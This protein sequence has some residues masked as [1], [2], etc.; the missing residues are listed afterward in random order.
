MTVLRQLT[1]DFRAWV[2]TPCGLFFCLSLVLC[3]DQL[4]GPYALLRYHDWF[5]VIVFSERNFA[6]EMLRHGLVSWTPSMGGMP[7]FVA[8]K[9]PYDIVN[10]LM[11]VVPPWLAKSLIIFLESWA[12]GAG[13]ERLLRTYFGLHRRTAMFGGILFVVSCIGVTNQLF[14]HYFPLFFLCVLDL[15][16]DL[17]FRLRLRAFLLV[18]LIFIYSLPVVSLLEYSSL[19]FLLLL[20]FHPVHPYRDKVKLLWITF[21]LWTLYAFLH[22]PLFFGLWDYVPDINRVYNTPYTQWSL[23]SLRTLLDIL[24]TVASFTPTITLAICCLPE[25]VRDRSARFS[26]A[27]VLL[28]LGFTTASMMPEVVTMIHGTFVEKI[29]FYQFLTPLPFMFSLFCILSLESMRRA[30]RLPSPIWVAISFAA[31]LPWLSTDHWLRNILFMLLGLGVLWANSRNLPAFLRQRPGLLRGTTA[32]ALSGVV[33]VYSSIMFVDVGHLIYAR[34]FESVPEL[35]A[36]AR[37]AQGPFRVGSLDLADPVAQSNGLETVAARKVLFNKYYKQYVLAATSPQ[38]ENGP[39]WMKGYLNSPTELYLRFPQDTLTT[40][41]DV[42]LNR[43]LP[44]SADMLHLPMLQAMNVQYILSPKPVQGLEA[45]ASEVRQV[46][47]GGIPSWLPERLEGTA[48]TR[49]LELPI[50]IYHLRETFGRAYVVGTPVVLENSAEVERALKAQSVDEL[51]RK[52][53]LARGEAKGLPPLESF[54]QH[55]G[56]VTR[57][58]KGPD[59]FTIEGEANGPTMIVVSNNWDKNWHARLNGAETPILRGNLAFQTVAVPAA[60]PFRLELEYKNPVV[61]W[62]HLASA[63]A[64]LG[65]VALAFWGRCR[66]SLPEAPAELLADASPFPRGPVLWGGLGTTG[67]WAVVFLFARCLKEPLASPRPVFYTLVYTMVVGVLVTLW[68]L[69]AERL[70][71]K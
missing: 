59:A 14:V 27:L 37:N 16:S 38:H 8:Q 70:G 71:R 5:D 68:W 39:A 2:R 56:R 30:G 12:A 15:Y 24:R 60:G 35:Q 33:M 57:V 25:M 42:I 49:G 19:H 21:L 45:A 22:L 53:F 6:Q 62:L 66:V 4:L 18:L 44:L 41:R 55:A 9:P 64:L 34:A 54:G 26:G 69:R 17:S 48:L 40:R 65:L 47:G 67:V 1:S 63:A 58:T 61:W 7:G 50:W 36:L 20:F 11:Y 13:M 23:K 43:G 3:V 32:A 10:V 29:D 51:R 46:R 52:V 28:F 31:T